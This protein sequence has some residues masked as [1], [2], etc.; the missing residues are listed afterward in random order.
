MTPRVAI[1]L[2]VASLA[3]AGCGSIPETSLAVETAT[4]EQVARLAQIEASVAAMAA[5]R[6]DDP[7]VA[8]VQQQVREAQRAQVDAAIQAARLNAQIEQVQ[9]ALETAGSAPGQL[10]S[11]LTG[12]SGFP[13]LPMLGAGAQQAFQ[14]PYAFQ[15]GLSGMSPLAQPEPTN[16]YSISAPAPYGRAPAPSPT[17]APATSV[18]VSTP[19]TPAPT[20]SDP[21][22]PWL[23][24]GTLLTGATAGVGSALGSKPRDGRPT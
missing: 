11:T 9:S 15:T 13:S 23:L 22:W 4:R 18:N 5:E 10:L 24:G 6:P 12:G 20:E 1:I 3:A 7:R 21:V 14:M 19:A 2:A 8:E 17:A 16:Y